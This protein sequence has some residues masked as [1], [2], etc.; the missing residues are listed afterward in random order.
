MAKMRTW[1]TEHTE[2]TKHQRL[3]YMPRKQG[4]KPVR[5]RNKSKTGRKQSAESLPVSFR[6]EDKWPMCADAI[7]RI[8]DQGHCGSC[9]A[10]SGLAP[11]DARMCIVSNGTW[12]GSKDILSRLHVLAC[13]PTLYT[14]H[15]DG[16]MGGSP[17]W[18]FEMM[19]SMGVVST[20][21]LP[22]LITGR[23]TEHFENSGRAPA[24]VSHCQQN[25]NKPMGQDAYISPGI[26]QYDELWPVFNDPD[27]MAMTKQAMYEEGPVSFAF[28]V[29]NEF[30]PYAGGVFSPCDG[31]EQANHAVY[32]FGWGVMENADGGEPIEFIEAL[33]SW[34]TDWGVNGTFRIHPMCICEFV[35]P[36]TIESTIANHSVEEVNEFWPWDPPMQCPVDEDGCV[37]DMEGD[38]NYTASQ[39]CFSSA[40][41]GKKIRVEEFETEYN[42]DYVKINGNIFWGSEEE[43]LDIDLLTSI[44]V[45]ENGLKFVSDTNVEFPGFK[46]CPVEPTPEDLNE[47]SDDDDDDDDFVAN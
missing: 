41:N 11:V 4:E 20:N 1:L 27:M 31:T 5:R 33:N 8:H 19:A 17:S 18:T 15:Y 9:W 44:I 36:G 7:L 40:L 12:V 34:G 45:D 35:I 46:L 37:T 6:A 23:G 39:L 14:D 10:F 3:G 21:C 25:Y 32:A 26:A 38:A 30:F 22:Y 47:T 42:Y 16:C 24:C 29:T 28:E 13:A 2:A 43:G